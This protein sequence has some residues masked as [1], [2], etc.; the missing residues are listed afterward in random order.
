MTAN[1]AKP[2][3]SFSTIQNQSHNLVL[4]ES[5]PKAVDMLRRNLPT[6]DLVTNLAPI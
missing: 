6:G 2:S 4:A 1:A 5:V 3:P